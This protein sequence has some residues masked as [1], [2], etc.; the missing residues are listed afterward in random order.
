VVV[1]AMGSAG[2]QEQ[3]ALGDV[4][5]IAARLQGLAEPNT[6]LLSA[7]TY[8]RPFRTHTRPKPASSRPHHSSPPAGQILGAARRHEPGPPVAAARQAD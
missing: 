1:G 6:I 7:D 2:R 3:V 5:N 4:P 8:R